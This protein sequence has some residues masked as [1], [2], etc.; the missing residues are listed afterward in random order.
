INSKYQG[1]N[2]LIISHGDPMWL[3]VVGSR[4]AMPKEAI[5]MRDSVYLSPAE[6]K[7]LPFAPISHNENYELDFHK[8]YID[9]V[10]F[11]CECGG[12]YKRV[13][14][15]FDCWFESGAMPYASVHY[16]FENKEK[17]EANFPADFIAEGLDQTRGWFYSLM[18]LSTAI[19]DQP[20]FQ[21]VVVNGMVLAE[22]GQKMSKRLKNYPDLMY[23]VEK[24][25]AD[26]L[27]FYMI[28]SPIVRAEDLRFSERGVDEVN[29]KLIL[30][31]LNVLSFYELYSGEVGETGSSSGVSFSTHGKGGEFAP[32]VTPEYSPETSKNVLDI[33]I[34]ESL[35]N[36][37]EEVEHNLKKYE[38][39]KAARPLLDFV[40]EFSTWYIRRS[41]D[42]FKSD[43]LEDRNNAIRT[44]R[45][46][47]KELSKIMAPFVPFLAEEVYSKVKEVGDKESVHLEDWPFY[48]VVHEDELNNK[49]KII[50]EMIEV[51]KI[52]TL[53][54]DERKKAG[55]SVRQPLQKL[56]IKD[57]KLKGSEYLVGLLELIMD[58][59]NV[60]EVLFDGEKEG[61]VW[62][63]T[64]ITTELKE[65]GNLRELV[66]YIQDARK[67]MGLTP[68]QKI[69]LSFSVG[70]KEKVFLEKYSSELKKSVTAEAINYLEAGTGEE[71]KIGDFVFSLSI[72]K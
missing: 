45:Y 50:D 7:D 9:E 21:Q 5:A 33:W 58:E 22:D 48:G 27:R 38:L 43:D 10:K 18:V 12:N 36:L 53:T 60:K 64:Y 68:S 46:V 30:K 31:L 24:Y 65:E 37:A 2:I 52:V 55:F 70:P 62:L 29:K 59:V 72:E 11:S 54:L 19:F 71:I 15:V 34:T 47:L 26:A 49:K 32:K 1:K 4:G 44:T 41:R 28:N 8:P 39:D 13:P 17:F 25:G 6:F 57:D 14:E 40:D 63:D 51:R 42:R 20:T 35:H 66:R 61:D 67:G 23:V 69:K 3:L 16:P 56:T